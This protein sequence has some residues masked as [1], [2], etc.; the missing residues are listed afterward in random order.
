MASDAIIDLTPLP[1]MIRID[2]PRANVARAV[3]VRAARLR[4]E[5]E[6]FLL[7]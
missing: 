1:A 5:I 7:D 3:D 4:G 6:R 2:H